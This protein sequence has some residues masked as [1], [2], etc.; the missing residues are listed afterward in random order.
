MYPF[1]LDLGCDCDHVSDC[2]KS[3]GDGYNEVLNQVGSDDNRD[4]VLLG[5][6][7][8]PVQVA[9]APAVP[10]VVLVVGGLTDIFAGENTSLFLVV[11]SVRVMTGTSIVLLVGDGS[12]EFPPVLVVGL[13]P[14]VSVAFVDSVGAAAV[15]VVNE[16]LVVVCLV[17][18][19]HVELPPVLVVG[20]IPTVSVA[21][22]DSVGA[23]A[24]A[25]VADVNATVV[26]VGLVGLGHV[27]L[28]PVLVVGSIPTVSVVFVDS[29]HAAAVA[30]VNATVVV[31]YLVGLG[32]VEIV[33]FALVEA[34]LVV[35]VPGAH[36]LEAHDSLEV[37]VV[38]VSELSAHVTVADEIVVVVCSVGLG[39]GE[40][41][42]LALVVLALVVV[43]PH[44][45]VL[46][47]SD[48]LQIA[49]LSVLAALSPLVLVHLLIPVL[50]YSLSQ[51]PNPFPVQIPIQAP[52]L[53]SLASLA[54]LASL[55]PRVRPV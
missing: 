5:L 29:V 47:A 6:Y 1:E 28:P 17:G 26:V 33:Q 30:V 35:V 45:H 54:S 27:E 38:S 36:V 4:F 43:I 40:G 50:A 14:T 24:A 37:S 2:E 19:G 23:A 22:V 42:Q 31:V 25:A 52:L 9:V 20:L 39:H 12:V 15:A 53:L 10:V 34:A 32:H 18:L 55:H 44:A 46:V 8:G 3:D 11:V 16:A 21:F 41:I 13:I 51:L 49:V 7:P 48:S